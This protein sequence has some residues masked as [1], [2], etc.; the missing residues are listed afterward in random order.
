MPVM[1]VCVDSVEKGRDIYQWKWKLLYV[2]DTEGCLYVGS[3][4]INHRTI[5]PT[6][7][8]RIDDERYFKDSRKLPSLLR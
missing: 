8:Y 1:R 7:Q 6:V 2:L 3:T 4:E 5:L